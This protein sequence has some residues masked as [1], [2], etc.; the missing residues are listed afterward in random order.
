MRHLCCERNGKRA[1]NESIKS[2]GKDSQTLLSSFSVYLVMCTLPY[3][4]SFT[5]RPSPYIDFRSFLNILSR[6]F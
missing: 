2:L 1:N 5:Y 6:T 3:L 4:S